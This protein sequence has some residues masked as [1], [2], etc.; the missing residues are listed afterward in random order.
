MC[1]V[2]CVQC[3]FVC[4]ASC[5][6]AICPNMETRSPGHVIR[7]TGPVGSAIVTSISVKYAIT[8]SKSERASVQPRKGREAQG[9][10]GH[11]GGGG[12]AD[13]CQ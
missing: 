1:S 2:M 3:E 8:R 13:W 4:V 9:T 6:L 7:A 12:C 11:Y 5:I 10:T